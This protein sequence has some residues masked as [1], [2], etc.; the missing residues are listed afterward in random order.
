MTRI[1]ISDRTCR[2]ALHMT[3]ALLAAIGVFS[4]T[5]Y[6]ATAGFENLSLGP[7][8]YC[9]DSEGF[10]SQ[11]AHFSNSFADG[12]WDGWAYS[13]VNDTTTPGYDNQFAAYT[14]TGAGGSGNYSV[15]F[16]SFTGVLPVITLPDGMHIQSAM[17][18]NT[19]YTALS[20]LNG[21]AF[22][23]QFTSEDWFKLTIV[24]EDASHSAVGSVD[25]YLAQ[26]GSILDTWQSVDL[27][28]LSAAKTL[29][30][31]LASSDNGDFGMNTPAYFALDNL[32][33]LLEGDANG[34]DSVNGT[35]L[36]TVLS[37]YNDSGMDWIDG[38]FNGDGS[39]NGTDLNAVLSNYNQSVSATT[40]VPE[41][42]TLALM[43]AGVLA[44]LS[45]RRRTMH[46]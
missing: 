5:M 21:D 16:I 8:S 20:M 26:D 18:T 35:D 6:G 42:S 19:T 32:T 13:N 12:F 43:A 28:S 23:K 33:F 7:D 3:I 45:W 30:F 31:C 22:A 10:L 15:G 44:M 9:N 37:N 11:G 25:F 34:D 40:S 14:G 1:Q 36:N 41:P 27:G 39:V 2:T 17:F 24:G 29:E 4:G 38:D 46:G